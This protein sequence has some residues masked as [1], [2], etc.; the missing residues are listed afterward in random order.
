MKRFFSFLLLL[1][2]CG[3]Q[4]QLV[5][6]ELSAPIA[7]ARPESAPAL[8]IPA[9]A[10]IESLLQTRGAVKVIVRLVPPPALAGGFR[11]EA[12]IKETAEIEHQRS[13]AAQVRSRVLAHVSS[14]HAAQ[15]KH[16]KFIPFVALEVDQAEYQE[17]AASADVDLIE[18]DLL[19]KPLL[20]DSI[21]LI[22]G[23]N[24][25]FEGFSGIGQAVAILDTGVDSR[26]PFLAN[27]VVAEACF[28]TT[29]TF[30]ATAY[31]STGS[32]AK[33]SGQPCWDIVT[34]GC[35]HGTH[36]AGIATGNNGPVTAP[37]G[38]AKDA[39][40]IAIQIFS[41]FNNRT[42]CGSVTPCALSYTSDMIHALEHVYNLRNIFNIAS[43]NMSLGSPP[44]TSGYCDTAKTSFK[45]AVDN[46]RAVGIATVVAAGNEG[47]LNTIS[48]PACISSAVSV[49]A[50]DKLDQVVHF[51]NSSAVLN[52]LAPGVSITS[53]VPGGGYD[54]WSGTSMAA[55]HVAGAL[56]VLKSAKPDAT[57]DEILSA[58]KN[59]GKPVV[60]ARQSRIIPRI[61]VDQALANLRL[62]LSPEGADFGDILIGNSSSEE[63]FI[64]SNIDLA[65]LKVSAISTVGN[66]SGMFSINLG[67]GLNGTC[68]PLPL[69]IT[70]QGTCSFSVVF[71]PTDVGP[72]ATTLRVVS[73][74][75]GTVSKDV[76]LTGGGSAVNPLIIAGGAASTVS[77]SVMLSLEYSAFIPRSMQFL[78]D[79]ASSWSAWN[80]FVPS[81]IMT[82][83]AGT[84][85]RNVSVRF[86]DTAGSA[87]GKT[88][89]IYS[90]TIFLDSSLPTGS[91]AIADGSGITTTGSVTLNLTVSDGDSAPLW[92]RF[93]N[94]GSVW[95]IWEAFS[96]TKGYLLDASKAGSKKVYVQFKSALTDVGAGK[97]SKS[98]SDTIL[99]QPA[100]LSAVDG[101]IV[102]SSTKSP[103]PSPGYTNSTAVNLGITNPDALSNIWMSFSFDTIKWSA[104]ETVKPSKNLS[105]PSGDG[106]KSV[107]V[108]FANSA[109][110]PGAIIYRG[111]I[112]LDNA[113]PL[114]W[115]LING[116]ATVTNN[117]AVT[118]TSGASDVSGIMS[119]ICI[120]ETV[121]A[122]TPQ[123]FIYDYATAEYTFS[124]NN[125][126][127]NLYVHQMD[128]AGK[129]SAPIKASI[130]L[131]T[132]GP[133]GT[134]VI[135]NGALSTTSKSVVLSLVA[136]KAVYMRIRSDGISW[137]DWEPFTGK[138]TAIIPL[139]LGVKSVDVIFKDAA[140]N[141]SGI[142]S[143]SIIMK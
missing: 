11:L 127:R 91:I 66:S 114:G 68:G 107:Y 8:S 48:F 139:G 100:V 51:S 38:V 24:G 63:N 33:D 86:K 57:V 64:I 59:S 119:K 122:C 70:P 9:R 37:S 43:V 16:F 116:G 73:G 120:K 143:D 102:I 130:V 105:L 54:T 77:A 134:V 14:R 96:Q 138:R 40:I 44:Y 67:D 15:A 10:Q 87:A 99:Y 140:G 65:D 93:S 1:F 53:S 19:L 60:D 41:Q 39:S 36:V 98:Y 126:T 110:V 109:K 75:S 112:I 6:A 82:L 83:P 84:G 104:W 97:I 2:V 108:R 47:K 7:I 125:G 111:S 5:A 80:A 12:R 45:Q 101:N 135:N 117:P 20:K 28:S 133:V 32:T 18:E 50:T 23:V 113:V 35:D 62:R 103:P 128:A 81:K 136:S 94:N 106:V 31:C 61:Q 30:G 115:V 137:G 34:G 3:S 129:I 29:D 49:G 22:G 79:K 74:N 42:D 58:L 13:V 88:S 72:Q 69:T 142:V 123:E 25:S 76:A 78:V 90:A 4:S 71:H 118:V 21:P 132:A 124:S 85:P 55:P 89:P 121:A 92:M 46:L 52:L 27:K 141:E 17:L 131:D 56:A 26:H 95:S